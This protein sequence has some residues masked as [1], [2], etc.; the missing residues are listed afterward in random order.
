MDFDTEVK[1]RLLQIAKEMAQKG[2][3]YAQESLVLRGMEEKHGGW[4]RE[5]NQKWNSLL[6]RQQLI[7]TAWNDLFRERQ[8]SWGYDIDNPSTPFFHVTE[9]EAKPETVSSGV[10]S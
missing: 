1:E 7:L 8:L 5:Q 6:K 2:A 4:M 3:G 10:G 9:D